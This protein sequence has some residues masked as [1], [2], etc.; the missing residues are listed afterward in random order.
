MATVSP[1]GVRA[2]ELIGRGRERELLD[3]LLAEVRAGESRALVICGEPGI[4]K[5]T[6]LEYVAE[7]AV[8]FRVARAA[9]VQSEMEL[10]FAGLH[11]LL[12]PMLDR[13][14]G[15]PAPQRDALTTA[16]G[17]RAG[18]VPDRFFVGLAVLSLLADVAEEEPLICL[19]DDQQWLD[20]ASAQVLAFVARRLGA[21]SVGLVFTTRMAGDLLEGL[22]ELVVEG[23]PERDGRALLDSLLTAPLDGRVRDQIVAETSGNPLALIELIRELTPR[24][25]Q[26]A[27]DSLPGRRSRRVSRTASGGASRPF[28]PIPSACSSSRRR[29]QSEIRYRASDPQPRNRSRTSSA[30]REPSTS[31]HPRPSPT[32]SSPTSRCSKRAASTSSSACPASPTTSS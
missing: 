10:A 31:A 24:S 11:Q 14:D 3:R 21:E 8:G 2:R 7:Q 5:S 20:R 30:P 32:R 6:L 17:A 23:L 4:G 28:P 12:A 9:A 18:P 27:S 22:P 19:V 13:L 15:L 25:W 16:F 1:V 26:A 29:T